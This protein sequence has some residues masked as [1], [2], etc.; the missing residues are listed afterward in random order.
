VLAHNE[1]ITEAITRARPGS[2]ERVPIPTRRRG[3]RA[4]E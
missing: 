2:Y 1:A 3:I 4:V